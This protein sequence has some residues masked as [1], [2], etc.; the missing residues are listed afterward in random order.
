ML[1]H[2]FF[3]KSLEMNLLFYRRTSLCTPS[4]LSKEFSGGA[5][6]KGIKGKEL[7]RRRRF[8]GGDIDWGSV[9]DTIKGGLEKAGEPFQATTGV[10]PAT[11][12]Y[13]LG[14]DVIGP[15]LDRAGLL[16][17]GI[18]PRKS[19][20]IEGCAIDGGISQAYANGEVDT[21]IQPLEKGGSIV[22]PGGG[23]G[24]TVHGKRFSS[25]KDKRAY[26]RSLRRK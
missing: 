4:R 8:H 2:E 13:Q 19:N 6:E 12:G 21:A 20:Y 3:L 5:I 15:A 11:L 14:H 10:N 24:L 22:S 1:K 18:I 25:Q 17:S 26:L 23:T 7:H 9:L 16:G